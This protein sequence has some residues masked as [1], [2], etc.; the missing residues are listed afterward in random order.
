VPPGAWA[1]FVQVGLCIL[2]LATS[3]AVWWASICDA[4]IARA[5]RNRY[6][7]LLIIYLLPKAI[8]LVLFLSDL[9]TDPDFRRSFLRHESRYDFA[10][11]F[12]YL[13]ISALDGSAV[14]RAAR[15]RRPG[16][17]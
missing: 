15:K 7:L 5:V 8:F 17:A 4:G 10:Q 14:G 3:A 13:I 12:L 9:A 11:A 6:W 16:K 1:D 2:L